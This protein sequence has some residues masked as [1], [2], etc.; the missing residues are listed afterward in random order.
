MQIVRADL[1]PGDGWADEANGEQ[2]SAQTP[3]R[4]QT[5]LE[6]RT[7]AEKGGTRRRPFTQ[8]TLLCT[9][10]GGRGWEVHKRYSEFKKLRAA[11]IESGV[12]EIRRVQFPP[13]TVRH[14]SS[15]SEA[16]V[17][18]RQTVL[19]N[20]TNE[21]L[22]LCPN[23]EWLA[24]FLDVQVHARSPVS[25][26]SS[27]R[28]LLEN[29]TGY[30]KMILFLDVQVHARSLA[31]EVG[32]LLMQESALR[33]KCRAERAAAASLQAQ[34]HSAET[35]KSQ[36]L[37]QMA[38]MRTEMEDMQ[39]E[40]D[41]LRLLK[42]ELQILRS[43]TTR[44]SAIRTLETDSLNG[45]ATVQ[46]TPVTPVSEARGGIQSRQCTGRQTQS[47]PGP[48]FESNVTEAALLQRAKSLLA[49]K[50]CDVSA[51]DA[52]AWS[53][54]ALQSSRDCLGMVRR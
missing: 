45:K 13:K 36:A 15:V 41:S 44:M 12:K 53:L 7:K 14:K 26:S 17:C 11:L 51:I 52:S 28:W 22:E 6:P 30:S 25:F 3:R 34:L 16:R 18:D 20:W 47:L 24:A 50:S 38:R 48:A 19:Q 21:V 31:A 46:S 9:T 49:S 40:I 39:A 27:Q 37:Q 33:Q 42:E 35:A 4:S 8:Y 43:E 5:D 10:T 1:V 29:D 32:R 2:P 54:R 23:H